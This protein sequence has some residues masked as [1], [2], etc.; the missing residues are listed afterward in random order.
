M[1]RKRDP[2]LDKKENQNR[3]TRKKSEVEEPNVSLLFPVRGRAR[4]SSGGYPS[5]ASSGKNNK[6]PNGSLPSSHQDLSLMEQLE[7]TKRDFQHNFSLEVSRLRK[8]L[9][10]LNRELRQLQDDLPNQRENVRQILQTRE[11][12]SSFQEKLNFLLSGKCKA[13]LNKRLKE[14]H[15]PH[16]IDPM[17]CRPLPSPAQQP[18]VASASSR[19]PPPPPLAQF[20]PPIARTIP[21]EKEFEQNRLMTKLGFYQPNPRPPKRPRT[22][23]HNQVDDDMLLDEE[24]P[25]FS[26]VNIQHRFQKKNNKSTSSSATAFIASKRIHARKDEAIPAEYDIN[27]ILYIPKTHSEAIQSAAAQ[28]DIFSLPTSGG[29]Q[30]NPPSLNAIAKQRLFCK[31]GIPMFDKYDIGKIFCIQCGTSSDWQDMLPTYP[32]ENQPRVPPVHTKKNSQI[33]SALNPFRPV[34]F[35]PLTSLPFDCLRRDRQ[36][37]VIHSRRPTAPENVKSVFQKHGL[38]KAFFHYRN[39]ITTH[40]TGIPPPKYLLPEEDASLTNRLQKKPSIIADFRTYGKRCMLEKFQSGQETLNL[41]EYIEKYH[42]PTNP[43]STCHDVVPEPEILEDDN[44]VDEI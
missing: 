30:Q 13:L 1:K 2:D 23:E 3:S 7:E 29:L 21:Q 11:Q 34:P 14:F 16:R 15:A 42:P 12:I 43:S 35:V 36:L 19:T 33:S 18:I 38:A 8:T 9:Q 22:M 27:N 5:S 26:H 44:E 37:Q 28:L 31:C 24:D 39:Q 17:Q 41:L 25:L 6:K 40:F 10:N 4:S 20:S 32:E